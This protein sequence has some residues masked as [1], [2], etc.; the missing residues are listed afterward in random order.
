MQTIIIDDETFAV[1]ALLR[2]LKK[3]DPEGIHIGMRKV[4]DFL[5]YIQNHPVDI[6]F[7]DVDLYETNGIELTR[8]LA[9]IAPKLNVIIYTGHPQY[10][11]E[12][13]DLYVSGYLVKPVNQEELCTAL[14]H[15][16]YPVKTLRVQCFG[17]FGVFYGDEPVLFQKPKLL[18]LFAYLV[19][20]R[21]V[22]VS[23][24][25]G[26]CTVGGEYC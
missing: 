3:V 6:A 14:A 13:M 15:L 4:D 2:I 20:Q 1:N 10:K 7:V 16:R 9:E 22:A 21:G 19:F 24:L 25:W 11:Y 23:I 12:A 5:A 8:Q 26:L 18:E 17:N